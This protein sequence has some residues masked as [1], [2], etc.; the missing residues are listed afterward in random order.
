M[1]IEVNTLVYDDTDD[2]CLC[3][4]EKTQ[5][6]LYA[7]VQVIDTGVDRAQRFTKRY[8]GEYSH[9]SPEVSLRRIL[10]MGGKWPQ[11]PD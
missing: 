11:L 3:R 9:S 7:F 4:L 5:G 6:K 8:W 2:L 1:R 10:E